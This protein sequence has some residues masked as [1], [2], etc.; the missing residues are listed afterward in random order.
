[1]HNNNIQPYLFSTYF[2]FITTYCRYYRS[3]EVLLGVMYDHKIDVWSL[4]CL[5]VEMY[6]GT[7]LFPGIDQQDQL[8]RIVE[9]LGMPPISMI[10]R[11]APEK[12]GVVSSYLNCFSYHN[13]VII[14][15]LYTNVLCL[16]FHLSLS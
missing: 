12:R 8:G 13:G 4:A 5:L 15:V 10:E 9:V 2:M 1:M 16:L 7:P 11:M 14:N 3:P 6:T